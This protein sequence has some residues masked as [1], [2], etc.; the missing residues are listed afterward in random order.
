MKTMKKLLSGN[1]ALAL[2]AYHAGVAFASAYPGTPSTEIME[3]VALH[4]DI[5]AEWSTNEKVAME[6]AMGACYAGARAM[7]SMKQV[8][9][10]VAA[11]PFLAVATTGV[12]GGLVL[13]EADDPGIHSSQGEQDNRHFAELAKVPVLEPTDSQTAYDLMA[14][15]FEISEQF[16]TPVILRSTTRISHSKSIVDA[17]DNRTVP[18]RKLAFSPNMQKWVMLPVNARIR[19]TFM[20]ERMVKLAAYAETFPFN[21]IEPG[22]RQL[23]IIATGIS[24]QYARE[25]FPRA[26]FLKLGMTYPL[27]EKLI[28]E[29]AAKVDR[30]LV[31]EEL[32]PFLEDHIKAMG[33]KVEGK[34]YVPRTGELNS[35]II[36]S[37]GRKMGVLNMSAPAKFTVDIELAKRPPL[38]CP[39][40]PHSGFFYVLAGMGQ[41]LKL[42]GAKTSTSKESNM[43][44]AGDIGC[45]TLGAY[46]PLNAMDTNGCMGSSIGTAIG[47]EKVG[48]S[49]KIVAVIGDSTFLHSGITPLVDA[50]YNQST[51]T[52]VIL[53]NSTTAMTGHQEHPGTGVSVQGQPVGKVV[54]EDVVKGVG[55]KNLAVVDSF[56][57]KDIRTALK[58]AFDSHQLSVIIVRG[59][60]A[61]HVPKHGAIQT[62][63]TEKCNQCGICLLVGCPAIQTNGKQPVIDAAMC[64]GCTICQ[65]IC[66]KQAIGPVKAEAHN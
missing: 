22:D 54:L 16:D 44:I 39:G 51:I 38:L 35:D 27:P 62:V 2:G 57:L 50:V 58:N 17:K 55:V 10:N 13:I 5:Y 46:P 60:C 37:A 31:V 24:Y 29:F 12:K 48:L 30:I 63:D 43:V 47:M 42:P 19:H 6:V 7:V 52:V 65:Q 56:N 8:G 9:L 28:H 11:D 23:G 18:D 4:Q 26:T 59:A 49:A 3:A 32:D 64:S 14:C 40:C 34:Q 53:D 36:A 1:E 45:Y 66:P 61:V 41:R 21:K 20:E 33:I 15:A 25:V